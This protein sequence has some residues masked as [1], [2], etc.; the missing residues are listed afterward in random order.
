MNPQKGQPMNLTIILTAVS[1]M[2]IAGAG[3]Y[4]GRLTLPQNATCFGQM[5]ILPDKEVTE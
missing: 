5:G 4:A 1:T 3:F 2:A